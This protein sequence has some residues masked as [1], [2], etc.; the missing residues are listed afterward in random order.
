[1]IKIILT[2]DHPALREGIFNV[3][4][5]END[6]QV[7]GFSE[8]GVAL[9]NMLNDIKP[10]LILIDINMP[11]M[12][13]LD[14]IK[15]IKIKYPRIKL[16]VFSQYDERRFVKRVVKEGANGYL[17]KSSGSDEIVKAIRMV[18]GGGMYLSADLPNIFSEN[19][20]SK[21]K[22]DYLF[23]ELTSREMDILTLIC[24]GKTTTEIAV[25]LFISFNTVESHRSNILLKVGVK[26][27]A[28]LVKWALENE[29][30]N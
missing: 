4:L 8:N 27:T 25:A 2:D 29:I 7:I 6:M 20:N 16:I 9:L 18:M 28:G 30:V 5:Q 21:P 15:E 11:L 26:N 19:S 1:M 13:G 14:A 22:S 3:L 12:N 24:E 17:L 23:A 10:D